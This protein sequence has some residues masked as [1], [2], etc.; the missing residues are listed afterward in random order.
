MLRLFKLGLLASTV[1]AV[2][3][4][5]EVKAATL[6]GQP[7]IVIGHRGA[8]GLRPEHTLAAYELAIAQGAD[9]IEP[10]LVATKD[11]VL[12][13]R[14]ENEISGTT[15]VAERPEFATRK[16]TKVI[17]GVTYT[18][19][20]TEDFTL[21]ELKTLRAKER[22]PD[23]RPGNTA[24][25]G[26]FEVPTLQEVIDLAQRKSTELGRTIGIY[27]ETKHP[28]YFDSIGLSL[29]EPLV[30]TLNKNGYIGLNAPVFIQSF[31]VGNLQQLNQL[32]DVPLVQLFGG[33]TEKP[34]DFVLSGDARTYGDLTRPNA[35]TAI[36]S[37]ANGIGP[38]KRLIVPAATVD[39]NQDGKPDDL[40]GDGVISDA[41]RFL[42]SPTTLVDD[43]HTAGLLVHPYTFRNENFFLAQDYN[44]NPEREYEQ[45]FAL[46]VDGVFSDFPGTAVQVRNRVA[47]DP[48]GGKEVPEPGL[49]LALGVIPVAAF[50]RRR[51]TQSELS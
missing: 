44:G 41:D 7:P 37:Y 3:P 21:A 4:M 15:D 1:L 47:G 29:E 10:D 26:Q 8:S 9:Y 48:N 22:I 39:Q 25:D 6:T 40:N 17:D 20:F 12:V 28:S 32:T 19:W 11:G 46:G 14:H 31:E 23:L 18:G 30:E 42:Q 33:A 2:W 51:R 24:F 16:A 38:S 27:P 50:L 13:A 36:A 45:F 43:A 35:L 49:T 5:V 34:Y